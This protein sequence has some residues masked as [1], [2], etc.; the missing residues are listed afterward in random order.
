M[1]PADLIL[2]KGYRTP[3]QMA[4]ESGNERLL[5]RL[6]RK[7]VSINRNAAHHLGWTALQAAEGA[8]GT[9]LNCS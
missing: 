9:L 1:I 4:T 5:R 6:L 8:M 3:L 2:I 7:K